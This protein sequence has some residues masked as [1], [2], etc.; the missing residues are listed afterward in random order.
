MLH[1]LTCAVCF[2]RTLRCLFVKYHGCVS[3]VIGGCCDYFFLSI[4]FCLLI[5]IP[6]NCCCFCYCFRHRHRSLLPKHNPHTHTHSK[7]HSLPPLSFAAEALTQKT[8]LAF[9]GMNTCLCVVWCPSIHL[10]ALFIAC[11]YHEA[12][13]HNLRGLTKQK[14][15]Q[16]NLNEKCLLL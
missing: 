7:R 11:K 6:D 2:V 12:V 9:P 13:A 14:T 10:A 8:F 3:G 4:V 15:V 1:L 16:P 5:D